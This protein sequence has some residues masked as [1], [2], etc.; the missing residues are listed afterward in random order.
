MFLHSS[1]PMLSRGRHLLGG[2]VWVTVVMDRSMP[3]PYSKDLRWRWHFFC[4]WNLGLSA[5]E[6]V[7]YLGLFTWTVERCPC[8]RQYLYKTQPPLNS[9][10][11]HANHT[12]PQLRSWEHCVGT[13]SHQAVFPQKALGVINDQTL[14]D[15]SKLF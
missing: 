8:R 12:T 7:Y 10:S 3:M 15:Q 14:I 4:V 11:F 5:E 9:P 2:S 6:A 1:F 13:Q